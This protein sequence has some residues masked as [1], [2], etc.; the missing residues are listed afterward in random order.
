M[1]LT[2]AA[3]NALTAT[4]SRQIVKQFVANGNNTIFG[5]AKQVPMENV[6]SNSTFLS[7]NS[8]SI[9]LQNP[10]SDNSTLTAI[11][12]KIPVK[13]LTKV[14]CLSSTLAG[15]TIGCFL[16]MMISRIIVTA[17]APTLGPLFV[18]K[19][20]FHFCAAVFSNYLT[21]QCR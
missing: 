13:G 6:Q 12:E 1:L 14:G 8:T 17:M 9:A 16:V 4:Y 5:L 19:L 2:S 21:N 3:F 11:L 20:N 10:T 18:Q 15:T 7:K